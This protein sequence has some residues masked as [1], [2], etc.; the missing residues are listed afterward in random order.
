MDGKGGFMKRIRLVLICSLILLVSCVTN[1]SGTVVQSDTPIDLK[2]PNVLIGMGMSNSMNKEQDYITARN[3]AIEDLASQLAFNIVSSYTVDNKEVNGKRY[4]FV[5]EQISL[6]IR[7]DQLEDVH[8]HPYS[9]SPTDGYV[10][11]ASILKSDWEAKRQRDITLLESKVSNLLNAAEG[12]KSYSSEYAILIDAMNTLSASPYGNIA[13]GVAYGMRSQL[14]N[15]IARRLLALP[16]ELK[17]E[18]SCPDQLPRSRLLP[19]V[20]TISFGDSLPMASISDKSFSGIPLKCTMYSENTLISESSYVTNGNSIQPFE[21]QVPLKMLQPSSIEL[22]IHINWDALGYALDSSNNPSLFSYTI[23]ERK[24]SLSIRPLEETQDKQAL[25]IGNKIANTLGTE[26]VG[27]NSIPD[28]DLG[29]GLEYIELPE[30]ENSGLKFVTLNLV[31]SLINSN[32]TATPLTSY[33]VKGGGLGF[34]AAKRTAY[35]KL[36]DSIQKDYQWNLDFARM[37]Y[38]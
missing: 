38:F 27:Q 28:C 25:E 9:Y 29:I 7:Q 24:P 37:L 13:S 6:S 2:D 14:E 4:D 19:L 3:R 33:T 32:G 21:L 26:I 18:F 31:V 12:T 34:D 20:L 35:T 15:L 22:R 5:H 10:V 36:L 11:Y 8:I 30:I 1:Q 23:S 17:W 16:Q